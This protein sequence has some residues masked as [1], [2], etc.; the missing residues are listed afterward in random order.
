MNDIKINENCN[1][2]QDNT[3]CLSTYELPDGIK[4]LSRESKVYL[5]GSEKF[6]VGEIEVYEVNYSL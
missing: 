2:M 6:V 4:A 3:A 5:G 1:Y